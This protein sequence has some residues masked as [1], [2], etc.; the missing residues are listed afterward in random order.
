MTVFV[1]FNEDKKWI[2]EEKYWK[3]KLKFQ[4]FIEIKILILTFKTMGTNLNGVTIV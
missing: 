1:I 4:L 2:T 3:M